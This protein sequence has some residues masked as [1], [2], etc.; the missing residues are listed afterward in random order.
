MYTSNRRGHAL[1]A[2]GRATQTGLGDVPVG[3]RA[4]YTAQYNGSL[5]SSSDFSSSALATASQIAAQSNVTVLRWS[6]G[7]WSGLGNQTF[8][9]TLLVNNTFAQPQ[10]IQSILDNALYQAVGALPEASG[11]TGVLAPA[12]GQTTPYVGSPGGDSSSGGGA[13]SVPWGTIAAV[14]GIPIAALLIIRAV[15]G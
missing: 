5:F 6:G 12:P 2:P 8:T 13:S 3:S 15:R 11:V 9:A 4:T 14:V 7:S 10:D 1:C